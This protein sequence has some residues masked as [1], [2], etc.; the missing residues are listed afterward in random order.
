LRDLGHKPDF[1]QDTPDLCRPRLSPADEQRRERGEDLASGD[2][3]P[4]VDVPTRTRFL[5]RVTPKQASRYWCRYF[6]AH[7][8]VFGWPSKSA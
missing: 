8:D 6:R 2:A 3:V 1:A 4:K 5:D 7:R